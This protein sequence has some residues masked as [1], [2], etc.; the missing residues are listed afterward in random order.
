MDRD[1]ITQISDTYSKGDGNVGSLPGE[2]ID[3]IPKDERAEKI[4]EFQKG[5]SEAIRAYKEKL[6]YDFNQDFVDSITMYVRDKYSKKRSREFRTEMYQIIDDPY[7]PGVYRQLM[8][9][10]DTLKYDN[11]N[12]QKMDDFIKI[13]ELIKN[14]AVP[15][16]YFEKHQEAIQSFATIVMTM[17]SIPR[18]DKL[19]TNLT[20]V[21]RKAGIIPADGVIELER[22]GK[23][24]Y[25]WAFKI[26]GLNTEKDYVLKIFNGDKDAEG[27][28]G[29]LAELNNAQFWRSQAGVDTQRVNFY[30]GNLNSEYMI[31]EFIDSDHAPPKRVV[32]PA[33]FGIN[34][35]DDKD[36]N[37][38]NIY[39]K[40]PKTRHF[41]KHTFY[42]DYGGFVVFDKKL[43]ESKVTRKTSQKIITAPEHK[44]GKVWQEI[45]NSLEMNKDRKEV[46][47]GLLMTAYS[48]EAFERRKRL[49]LLK[50]IATPQELSLMHE[51]KRRKNGMLVR[52]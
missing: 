5:F 13:F 39:P 7:M 29:A 22:I 34:T 21:F 27:R 47:T 24:A 8:N 23:G 38:L 9:S 36:Y 14:T 33:D 44:K 42:P 37:E 20:E 40:N 26:E 28:H 32:N 31:T 48:F 1:K 15:Q 30:W 18:H 11:T 19:N 45:F 35:Q 2:L 3:R 10:V 51:Y 17:K 50:D 4:P 43:N 16:A 52:R 49:K 6:N 46:F 25:G 41:E 12:P